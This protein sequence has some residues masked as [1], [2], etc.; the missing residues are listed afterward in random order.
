MNRSLPL[1]VAAALLALAPGCANDKDNV[2]ADEQSGEIDFKTKSQTYDGQSESEEILERDAQEIRDQEEGRREPEPRP[3]PQSDNAPLS[4]RDDGRPS[5][6]FSGPREA[7][8]ELS[9]CAEALG[10]DMRLTREAAIDA[11]RTRLRASLDLPAG[12]PLPDVHVVRA[13]VWPLPNAQ[14]G[15]NRYAGYV[16]MSAPLQQ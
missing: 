2:I 13:W 4:V 8:A 14:A 16:L 5:W 7:E 10:P 3:Q 9:I 15:S 6:W 11:G 1:A 12:Q